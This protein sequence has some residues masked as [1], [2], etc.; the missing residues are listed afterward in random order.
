MIKK[1]LSKKWLHTLVNGLGCATV[2]F[3][4]G[5]ASSAPAQTYPVR[6][7]RILLPYG[8]GGNSDIAARLLGQKLSE[9]M[10][11]QIVID[12]RPGAG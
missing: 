6:P 1:H 11:Q 9:S 8:P 3:S 2:V 7:I 5:A 10:R 12:N 4:C